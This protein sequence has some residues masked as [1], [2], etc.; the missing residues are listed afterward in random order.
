MQEDALERLT[1]EPDTEWSTVITKRDSSSD[2]ISPD[3]CLIYVKSVKERILAFTF[4][5]VAA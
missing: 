4:L 3:E 2:Q 1:S 5:L